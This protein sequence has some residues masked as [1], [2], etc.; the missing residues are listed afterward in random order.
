MG[1]GPEATNLMK[2]NLKTGV[3]SWTF[4]IVPVARLEAFKALKLSKSES[5]RALKF[6]RLKNFRALKFQSLPVMAHEVHESKYIIHI[7]KNLFKLFSF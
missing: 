3:G 1:G 2:E 7:P 4:I 6:S 5:F